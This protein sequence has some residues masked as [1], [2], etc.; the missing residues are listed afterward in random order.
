MNDAPP[1]G[2]IVETISDYSGKVNYAKRIERR[3]GNGITV[4]VYRMYRNWESVNLDRIYG[5]K[6]I[7]ISNDETFKW[8]KLT[9]KEE[10]D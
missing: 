4:D 5:M 2:E 8:N 3:V 9:E 7:N 1:I 6:T 10:E